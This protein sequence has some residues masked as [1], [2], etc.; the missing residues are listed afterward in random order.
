M[1]KYNNLRSVAKKCLQDEAEALL[2]LQPNINEDFDRACDII[3]TSY[4]TENA[5]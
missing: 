1:I 2:A 5:K 4:G 3:F